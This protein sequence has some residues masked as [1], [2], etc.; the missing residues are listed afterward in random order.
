MA[1]EET[2]KVTDRRGR[3]PDIAPAEAGAPSSAAR[4]DAASTRPSQL[5]AATPDA[6]R[7]KPDAAMPDTAHGKPDLEALFVM[8]ASSALICLGEA[9]D[10]ATGERQVDLDQAR[11]A[12]DLLLLLRDKTEGN[13]TEHESRLLE[14]VLYDLQ[15]RFVDATG[16][17]PRA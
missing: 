8:F 5:D 2:F 6:A 15:M 17:A 4:H 14:Q 12:I 13:R 10:P 16:K 1:E 3:S 7:G 11:E 9:P